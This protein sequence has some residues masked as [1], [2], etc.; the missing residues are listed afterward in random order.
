MIDENERVF[1]N[2]KHFI[3]FLCSHKLTIETKAR[4]KNH[5]RYIIRAA[6]STLFFVPSLCCIGD[7]RRG[8]LLYEWLADEDNRELVDAIE[9]VNGHML[10]QLISASDSLAV[11]F[12]K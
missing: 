2:Q 12:C 8:K 1:G 3:Y 9:R 4:L 5:T 11:L 6:A 10:D 7:L